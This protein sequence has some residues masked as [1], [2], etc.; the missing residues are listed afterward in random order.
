M[1]LERLTGTSLGEYM[2]ENIFR[3]L[4]LAHISMIPSVEMKAKLAYMHQRASDGRISTT[5]HI[6]RRAV[7][8]KD[9]ESLFHSGGAGCFS[10]ASDYTRTYSLT[11]FLH[12]LRPLPTPASHGYRNKE[13]RHR[14]KAEANLSC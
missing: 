10:T 9:N 11:L 5:D 1:V 7:T 14:L 8:I 2:D 4:G 6:L 12:S 13:H 3:P